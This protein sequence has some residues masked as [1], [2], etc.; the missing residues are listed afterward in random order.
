MVK[1]VPSKKEITVVL[2]ND[3]SDCVTSIIRYLPR[4]L[5]WERAVTY[6][7]HVCTIWFWKLSKK[8]CGMRAYYCNI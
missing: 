8:S 6:P 1:A 4:S 3:W 5:H 7:E 2:C